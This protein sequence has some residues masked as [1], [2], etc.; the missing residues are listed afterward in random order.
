MIRKETK[1]NIDEVFSILPDFIKEGE[2]KKIKIRENLDGD[3]IKVTSKRLQTFYITG[4]KCV[5][6]GL[7]AKYFIKEKSRPDEP[8]HLNLYGVNKYGDEV[9]FTKDHIMP[10]SKGG[11]DDITNFQTMCKTCNFDK[12]DDIEG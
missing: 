7:E 8:Y 11:K 3:L 4:T 10:K 6:C 5:K 1:Y 9:L 2:W 12:S